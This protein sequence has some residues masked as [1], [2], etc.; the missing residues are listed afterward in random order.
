[1]SLLK[2]KILVSLERA[3]KEG[4]KIKVSTLRLLN[5]SILNCEK[6]KRRKIAEMKKGL[7]GKKLEK[8]SK[9]S[10]QEILEIIISEAKKKKEAIIGFEK[11]KRQDLIQKEKEELKVLEKYLPEQLND[12]R[13]KKLI[14][15]AIKETDAKNIKEIGKIMKFLM[16]KIKGKADAGQAVQIIKEIL[17]QN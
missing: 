15:N 17:S 2:N 7:P 9:L 4:D 13:L 5:A 12:E 3:L 8:S 16:P 11:G 1:M 10:N 14:I 6:E